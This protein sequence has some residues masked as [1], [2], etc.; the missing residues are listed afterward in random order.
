MDSSVYD[1][2]QEVANYL[3]FHQF[4]LTNILHLIVL[5]QGQNQVYC[6]IKK[7]YNAGIVTYCL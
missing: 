6:S 3:L 2:M 4:H 1:I 5:V 7:A